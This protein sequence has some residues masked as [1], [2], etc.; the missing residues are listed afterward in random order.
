[1]MPP[2]HIRVGVEYAA[3]FPA[4]L[5]RAIAGAMIRLPVL[6]GY[7]PIFDFEHPAELMLRWNGFSRPEIESLCG[8]PVSLEHTFFYQ[9]FGR[10]P[11]QAHFERYSALVDAMTSDRLHHA[12]AMTGLSVRYP[13]WDGAVDS[14]IR[15][16][17]ADYRYRPAEPKRM[18][19]DLLTRYVPRTLWD[20]PKHGFDFPLLE[21]LGADD[22][23]LVRRYLHKALWQRWQ[24]LAPAEVENFSRRFMAGEQRLMFRVWALVVLAVWLEGHP[25]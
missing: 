21:F 14:F 23:A 7:T 11:R 4:S 12:V 6:D 16:L 17:P 5:R 19:R 9:T 1:M 22:F 24:L 20:V 2:R 25:L 15:A 13:Y 8:E 18:L 10:F 3:L